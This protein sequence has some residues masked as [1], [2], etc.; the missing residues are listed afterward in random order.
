LKFQGADIGAKPRVVRPTTA[1]SNVK[2]LQKAQDNKNQ[3]RETLFSTQH[4]ADDGHQSP[5][6]SR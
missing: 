2:L 1:A 6:C 3:G 5:C 4:A